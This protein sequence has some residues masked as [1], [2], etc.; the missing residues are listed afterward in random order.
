VNAGTQRSV[1]SVTIPSAPTLDPCR[2]Q[3]VAAV[4]L[5]H[6]AGGGDELHRHDPGAEVA[7]RRPG[8]VRA[9]RQRAGQRL[10][11]DGAEVL[12]REA[13][14]RQPLA[15]RVQRDPGLGAHEAVAGPRRAPRPS[16]AGAR[17]CRR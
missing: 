13:E 8:P 15:Q 10:D 12:Q 9:S 6:L 5:A 16:A 3:Q 1:T 14:R 7:Q 17:A 2:A 11:I 4:D